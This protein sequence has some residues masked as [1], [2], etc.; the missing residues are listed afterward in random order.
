MLL[1]PNKGVFNDMLNFLANYEEDPSASLGK[2]AYAYKAHGGGVTSFLNDFFSHQ[3]ER[4][5]LKYCVDKWMRFHHPDVIGRASANL[6]IYWKTK[7]VSRSTESKMSLMNRWR[8]ENEEN[9][10]YVGAEHVLQFTG[11]KPWAL[12]TV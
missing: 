8:E 4:L 12:T 10:E 6:H 9:V 2:P 7:N 3:W 1:R 11:L 5:P